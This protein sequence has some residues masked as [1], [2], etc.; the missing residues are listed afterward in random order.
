MTIKAW[1]SRSAAL[2]VIS[3]FCASAAQA[4]QI[5][6][7]TLWDAGGAMGV[8][9]SATDLTAGMVTFEVTNKADST[10]QHEMFVIELTPDQV[11]NPDS[12]P[13]DE[14]SGRFDEEAVKDRGEVSELDPG[15]SGSITLDLKPGTYMLVCNVAGHYRAKMYALVTVK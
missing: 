5:E 8:S 6:N 3:V 15:Q 4:A 7:V 13:Y 10:H 14:A 9:V 11:A 1:V 2:A 12:L